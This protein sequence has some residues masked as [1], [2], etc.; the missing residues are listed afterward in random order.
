MRIFLSY[1][2][3]DRARAEEIALALEGRGHDVFFDRADLSGG[4]DYHQAIRD[5]IADADRFV[6]L[7]SPHSVQAGAYTLS[8]VRM[9]RERWPHPKQGVLPVLLQAIPL[10]QVPAYLRGVTIFQPEGDVAA[11]V[12]N[13]LSAPRRRLVPLMAG[14]VVLAAIIGIAAIAVRDRDNPKTADPP[15]WSVTPDDFVTRYV[16]DLERVERTEYNLDPTG[17]FAT[18]RSE[19]VGISRVAFG[20]LLDGAQA[21]R[22]DVVV[23]NSTP[24]PIQLDITSRF[25]EVEDDRGRKAEL[26]YFCCTGGAGDILGVG[27]ERRVQL[28]FR[29]PPGWHGKETQARRIYFHINGLLPL[30]RGTW[31]FPTLATAA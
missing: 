23:V 9:A 12:A 26:V 3:E 28:I 2:S 11:E 13:H 14:A 29:A 7:I 22:V 19:V 21:L 31:S 1:A 16:Y 20:T 5:R 8:E 4:E 10:D 27:Q 15:T 18:A 24:E 25:F 17:P 30:A 6:F